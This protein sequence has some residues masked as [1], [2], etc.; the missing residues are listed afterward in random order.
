MREIL[1]KSA[2]P[3]HIALP[4]DGCND[5]MVL[6]NINLSRKWHGTGKW[7]DASHVY[8]QEWYTINTVKREGLF[9]PCCSQLS[10][11]S[12]IVSLVNEHSS[13]VIL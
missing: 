4:P 3:R 13:A 12:C 8:R 5:I 2:M 6:H 11:I 1:H 10:C 9:Q 7:Q